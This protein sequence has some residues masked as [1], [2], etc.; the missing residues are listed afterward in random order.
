MEKGF[1]LDERLAEG[2]DE[3]RWDNLGPIGLELMARKAFEAIASHLPLRQVKA[4]EALAQGSLRPAQ[5]ARL[6][7][8]NAAC[9]LATGAPLC[10]DTGV[11]GVF[12]FAS[13]FEPDSTEQA[14][15]G[16][17][18]AYEARSLRNSV[19]IPFS[20]TEEKA[21]PGNYP[22]QVCL[23][24]SSAFPGKRAFVFF[25]KGGGSQNKTQLFQKT[26]AFLNEE[27]I[28]A[29]IDQRLGE[30]GTSACPPYRISLVVGGLSPEQ[31][32]MVAKL[33]SLGLYEQGEGDYESYIMQSARRQGVSV[34]GATVLRLCRHGASCPVAFAVT[35]NCDR[36]VKAVQIGRD[37]W[38]ERLSSGPFSG[39]A[40]FAGAKID[41]D[42]GLGQQV[43]GLEEGSAVLLSGEVIIA[44]DKAHIR[45]SKEEDLSFL[46][47]RPI[48][49]AGPC[50]SP[51]GVITSIGPTTASRMDEK[52]LELIERGCGLVTIA[53]GQRTEE[54]EKSLRSHGGLYFEVPG[55]AAAYIASNCLQ[56]SSILRYPEL[57]MEAVRLARFKDLPAFLAI[58]TA[59]GAKL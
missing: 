58:K 41:L 23:Q 29:F 11:A 13:S 7:L 32:L 5:E 39:Y 50:T 16:A 1:C 17:R 9:S 40:D 56:S 24:F 46:G 22:A 10:Q 28:K 31:T 51:D 44:R 30:L 45:F 34:I 25:A 48:F 35:C 55:G 14:L 12:G 21:W 33:A 4:F 6:L 37:F 18:S 47:I 52:G 42:R 49:Y 54:Y 36:T 3:S 57:G 38:M 43:E 27:A 19:N 15:R 8:A 20:M 59:E 53:K 2:F 26:A